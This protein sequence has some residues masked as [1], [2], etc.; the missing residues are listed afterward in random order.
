MTT[1]Y[2]TYQG[3]ISFTSERRPGEVRIPN[4]VYDIWMPLLG[5]DVLGAY[6]VYCRLEREGV[7][8]AMSQKRLAQ[9]M[10][11][12]VKRLGQINDLLQRYDFIRIRKPQGH[13]KLM[14]WTTEIAVCDP[15][16]EIPLE[17]IEELKHP[18]GYEPLCPWL[19]APKIAPK[20]PGSTSGDTKQSLDK[21]PNGAANVA[22]SCVAPSVFAEEPPPADS[23]FG[24]LDDEYAGVDPNAPEPAPTAEELFSPPPEPSPQEP[25]EQQ[26]LARMRDKLGTDPLE[27]AAVTEKARAT[28]TLRTDP[29]EDGDPWADKPLR[30]FCVLA[31]LNY[32]HLKETSR[33]NWPNALRDWAETFGD[34]SPTPQETFECVQAI[35]QSEQKWKTFTT[36][37]QASFQETM[38]AMLNRIRSGSP[39]NIK[40][41]GRHDTARGVEERAQYIDNGDNP[42]GVR[43][44]TPEEEAEAMQAYRE[45]RID[46]Y[47]A[48]LSSL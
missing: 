46:E 29:G 28:Q 30:G 2:T 13:E 47:A 41:N 7:V 22:P 32:D 5:I 24:P 37:Y 23:T 42:L 12:G 17:T 21:A 33:H 11:I 18:Q 8:K 9:M 45:G 27:I 36:P 43:V 6:S 4:Y 26:R 1:H 16:R 31:G 38:D 35:A 48:S 34:Q 39:I 20:E 14:H 19:T 10:R 44:L 15:P 25:P 3:G 40:G